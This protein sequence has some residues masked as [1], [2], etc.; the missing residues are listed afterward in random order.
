[1]LAMGSVL[2]GCDQGAQTTLQDA[3]Q[4]V[5]GAA[6]S[7]SDAAGDLAQKATDA[8]GEGFAA[9]ADKASSALASIEGGPEMLTKVKEFFA[10]ATDSLSGIKDEVSARAALPKLDELE[11][12]IS[13]LADMT[14]GLPAEAKTAVSG[15]LESGVNGLKALV[16][17]IMALP[18]VESIVKPK[19]DAIMQKLSGLTSG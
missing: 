9:A 17:K 10:S 6:E 7:A 11:G 5:Q 14:A 3:G 2:V 1:M 19:L 18:G 16:E 4:A 8:L 13:G 12:K 15:L